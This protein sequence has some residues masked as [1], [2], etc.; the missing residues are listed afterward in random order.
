MSRRLWSFHGGIHPA[1]HKNEST[2]LPLVKAALAKQLILPLQQHIGQPA[3]A[4]VAV[5]EKVNKGQMIAQASGFIS[6][7]IHAPTSGTISDIRLHPIPHPSGL[8][9]PCIIIDP[10][11]KERWVDHENI[12]DFREIDPSALR[13]IIRDAGIVGLGG[14]GFPSFV[15]L[16]PGPKKIIDTL[17]INAIECEPYI[18][19]DD[20]LMRHLPDKIVG[21][22]HIMQYALHA[23]ECILAIEDN[24]PEAHRVMAERLEAEA[25]I[26]LVRLPTCYPQG[27]EKQLVYVLT[28]KEVPTNG[29]AVHVGV[30]C[31]N[32]GTA[33]AVYDAIELGR[34]LVS[35]Y[36]TITGGAVKAARNLE[37]PFGTPISELL[38]QCDT[39]FQAIERLIM[40]GP[41][42]GFSLPGTEIPTIKTTNAVLAAAA[43]D[44]APARPAMPCI[45]CG[46]CADACPVNLLPQQLYWFARARDVEKLQ[47]YN[48]FDCI[49]CGCCAYVCPS[50]IP[51][52]QYYRFAKG[53]IWKKEREKEQAD[54]ARQRHQ[55]RQQRL[56]REKAERAARHGRK[57]AALQEQSQRNLKQEIIDSSR[58]AAPVNDH[59]KGDTD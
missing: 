23:R 42:M 59:E 4:I 10:D 20:T 44:I 32:V 36:V 14:A 2:Q 54:K 50:N 15:K 8:T 18:S 57:K 31:H 21:G 47:D 29:L 49:E 53:E 45:R 11:G 3:E 30:V 27:S 37:V 40:G 5:G 43:A 55:F 1:Q 9:A 28:G 34:P 6:A 13:N 41:M 51:L 35:R 22:I 12:T 52:V 48:L 33:A 26:Q 19:C 17:I 46:A 25:D 39:D 58:P 24:K 38:E 56:A 16:N 7:P